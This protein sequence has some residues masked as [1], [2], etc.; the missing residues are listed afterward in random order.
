MKRKHIEI[1]DQGEES[2]YPNTQRSCRT[3]NVHAE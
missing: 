1:V 2:M 3:S